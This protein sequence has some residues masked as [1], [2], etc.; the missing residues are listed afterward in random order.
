MSIQ[1]N[2]NQSLSLMGLLASQT[3]AAEKHR[4]EK[5]VAAEEPAR[6]AALEMKEK[7]A[8]IAEASAKTKVE[9][10]LGLEA[11]AKEAERQKKIGELTQIHE[12]HASL[13]GELARNK[14]KMASLNRTKKGDF[15]GH[16]STREAAIKSGEELFQYAPSD[17]LKE[18]IGKWQSEVE[19][20]K[21]VQSEMKAAEKEKA[22]GE[23]AAAKAKRQKEADEAAAQAA[24]I[25]QKRLESERIRK[26]ILDIGGVR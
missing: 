18:N 15:P 7:E 26:M 11:K 1:A 20:I 4:V 25:E 5:R 13:V 23:K 21:G 8:R 2:I 3:P 17:I 24:E 10:R 12:K 14:D 6:E 22:R 16:I 9:E 19:E